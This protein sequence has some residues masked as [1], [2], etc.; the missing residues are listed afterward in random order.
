MKLGPFACALACAALAACSSTPP[1][2]QVETLKPGEATLGSGD[3]ALAFGK[4][5]MIRDNKAAAPETAIDKSIMI[6]VF[7]FSPGS[8]TD[9]DSFF[10]DPDGRFYVMLPS[11]QYIMHHI[12]TPHESDG[13]G[14]DVISPEVVFTIPPGANA[15]YLGVLDAPTDE[16][17]ATWTIID[18]FDPATDALRARNPALQVNPRSQLMAR[19]EVTVQQHEPA[20]VSAASESSHTGETRHTGRPAYCDESIG[21]RIHRGSGGN[22]S[23]LPPALVAALI[24]DLAC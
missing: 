13:R 17:T 6:A 19:D 24:L 5:E 8:A 16:G 23:L 1:H 12:I 11:G 15:I 4:I 21:E 9:L 10:T 3:R 20:H 14:G 22:P 18:E 7:R 2:L